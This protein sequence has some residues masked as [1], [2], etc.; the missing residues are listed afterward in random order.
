MEIQCATCALIEN[1]DFN[2]EMAKSYTEC[3]IACT[4]YYDMQNLPDYW[5]LGRR[6]AFDMLHMS[7]DETVYAAQEGEVR[8]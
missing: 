3:V 6:A 2:E 4:L 5:E 8:H 1:T 7:F